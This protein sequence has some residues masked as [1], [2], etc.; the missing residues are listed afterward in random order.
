MH[1]LCFVCDIIKIFQTFPIRNKNTCHH[2]LY[3]LHVIIFPKLL[4][5]FIIIYIHMTEK[6][7]TYFIRE[8]FRN[9]NTA[10]FRKTHLN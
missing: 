9:L 7:S 4:N 1:N 2:I 10:K 3:V 8:K 6:I 5:S